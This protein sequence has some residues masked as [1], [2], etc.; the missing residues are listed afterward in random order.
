MTNN[1]DYTVSDSN[2]D[3]GIAVNADD[4]NNNEKSKADLFDPDAFIQAV[5]IVLDCIFN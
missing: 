4:E 5:F 2:D 1:D 3:N